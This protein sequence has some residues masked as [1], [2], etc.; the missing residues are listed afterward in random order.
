MKNLVFS[1]LA[2]KNF[3]GGL[4]RSKLNFKTFGTIRA[5]EGPQNRNLCQNT[6]F[7]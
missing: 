4:N 1:D 5:H 7:P 2:Q 6:A 3:G